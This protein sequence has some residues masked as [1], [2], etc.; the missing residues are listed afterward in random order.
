MKWLLILNSTD[1]SVRESLP[2]YFSTLAIFPDSEVIILSTANKNDVQILS[3]YRPSSEKNLIIEN[4]GFWS[5]NNGIQVLNT[6]VPSRRR[7]DIQKSTLKTNFVV[8]K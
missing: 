5:E 2:D 7:I 6:K 8:K 1:D 3:A 4:R